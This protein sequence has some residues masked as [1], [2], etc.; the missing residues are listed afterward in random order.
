M[1]YFQGTGRHTS[2]EVKE[3]RREAIGALADYAAAAMA[4]VDADS[5]E[6]FWILG[7]DKPT[8]ADFTLFG[9]LANMCH[10]HRPYVPL[11]IHVSFSEC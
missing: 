2:D 3:M 10:A 11:S 4:K 6:P 9:Y 8:E 5:S 1:L 7:G